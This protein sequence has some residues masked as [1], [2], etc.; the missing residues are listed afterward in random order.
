MRF[1]RSATA[2]PRRW[3]ARFV[4][5]YSKLVDLSLFTLSALCTAFAMVSLRTLLADRSTPP[6]LGELATAS[7]VYFAGIGLW[8]I[9]MMRR[10]LSAA[11]SVGVGLTLGCG[12]LFG[13]WLLDEP[14]PPQKLVGVVA[15]FLGVL[16]VFRQRA[17]NN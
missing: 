11:Y 9:A 13:V 15:I 10:P 16:L 14:M 17:P 8:L 5:K 4:S 2:S 6:D 3:V 12:V 1:I 7:A